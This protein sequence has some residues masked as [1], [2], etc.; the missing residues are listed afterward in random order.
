MRY[1]R[2][3]AGIWSIEVVDSQ[4]ANHATSIALDPMGNPA[5]SYWVA[6]RLQYARKSGGAW[7]REI[8][9]AAAGS[10]GI[11]SSLA[12]DPLG[13]A[14]ISCGNQTTSDLL[15]VVRL[16][17]SSAVGV[18]FP[19]EPLGGEF[20][21]V[22][23]PAPGGATEL[24]LGLASFGSVEIAIY[25]AAGRR[26]RTLLDGAPGTSAQGLRWDGR[27]DGGRSAAPGVYFIRAD[28][29]GHLRSAR[30][31]VVR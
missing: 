25:D 10:V 17:D 18:D 29:D 4:V 3:S 12:F 1:A 22:P 19:A 5:I 30:V 14:S 9:N 28:V 6:G 8:A 13:R 15:Y 2:K 31:V 23:N 16:A 26:V 11:Y 7:V 21:V 27:D 24:L 20:F